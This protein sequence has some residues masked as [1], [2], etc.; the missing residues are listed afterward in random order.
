[1]DDQIGKLFHTYAKG[2]LKKMRT[3]SDPKSWPES[4][5]TIEY[6]EYPR[7]P[8]IPLPDPILPPTTL[9]EALQKRRSNRDFENSIPLTLSELSTI[10]QFGGGIRKAESSTEAQ[11]RFYPSGGARFPLELYIGTIG[12]HELSGG[13]YHYHVPTN[14]LEQL[15]DSSYYET[16]RKQLTYPFA[17]IA[18][19]VLI[20]TSIWGRN[21][22]KY[23]DFGYPLV[24]LEAGHLGQNIQLLSASLNVKT[25]PY[26]GYHVDDIAEILDIKTELE[27]PVHMVLMGK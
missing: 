25:C 5:K 7:F 20:V 10:L 1:M 16:L 13:I 14:S 19:M 2:L 24:N 27:A 18:P 12:N 9:Y 4:W 6:K 15:V 17:K 23:G 22:R 21:F 3:P 11:L 26:A 8:R